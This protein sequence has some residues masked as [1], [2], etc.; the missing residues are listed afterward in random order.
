MSLEQVVLQ[1]TVAGPTP[2]TWGNLLAFLLIL[3]GMVYLMNK[4]NV[5]WH[6]RVRRS[7]MLKGMKRFGGG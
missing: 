6:D 3:A 5:E 2:V 4:W 7:K 1:Q